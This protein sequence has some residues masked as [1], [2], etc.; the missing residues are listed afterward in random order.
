MDNYTI[1]YMNE[2]FIGKFP[3]SNLSKLE[4]ALLLIVFI[5]YRLS[6]EEVI[7]LELTVNERTDLFC[8][9]Q[10]KTKI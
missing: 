1:L 6:D 9:T 10:L 4:V 5:L 3:P 2:C 7:T 8:L